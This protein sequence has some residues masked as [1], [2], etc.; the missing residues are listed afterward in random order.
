MPP[1]L[2]KVLPRKA[3]F[4]SEGDAI[5]GRLGI[6]TSCK[7]FIRAGAITGVKAKVASLTIA[8]SALLC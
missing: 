3:F 1:G 5:K 8:N 7:M 4:V 2:E 6:H